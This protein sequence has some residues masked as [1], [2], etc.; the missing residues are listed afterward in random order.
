MA[1]GQSGT[2]HHTQGLPGA[3]F[4]RGK[5]RE[6]GMGDKTTKKKREKKKR[7]PLSTHGKASG[8]D[9]TQSVVEF[10]MHIL[11]RVASAA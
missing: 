6:D 1:P 4:L 10:Q 5:T 9:V 8:R 7:N 2:V 11:T 3:S